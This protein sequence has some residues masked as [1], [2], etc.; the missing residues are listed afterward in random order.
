MI[1]NLPI[2]L[3]SA[4][5]LS[6]LATP[7][8]S[9]DVEGVWLTPAQT[10]KVAIIDCGDGTPCGT[11]AWID[12]TALR[13]DQIA[14]GGAWDE[15]NP[16]QS[17]QKRPLIGVTILSEF[18]R[19]K[20]QWK[21]GRIYDPNDGKTYRSVIRLK[22]DG[23]LEVKGCIGPFCQAQIWT[24]TSLDTIADEDTGETVEEISSHTE[25]AS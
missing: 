11:I 15:N 18:E 4:V 22:D 8:F 25:D 23:T 21:K 2:A 9:L 6:A 13:P 24:K 16:D 1:K 10:S 3:M 12:Q 20:N 14:A 7:A 5:I 17:K 19:K